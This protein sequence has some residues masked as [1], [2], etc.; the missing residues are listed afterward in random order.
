MYSMSICL[1]PMCLFIVML[2]VTLLSMEEI[3]NTYLLT[4][5]YF[6]VKALINR[7]TYPSA[8]FEFFFFFFFRSH[9]A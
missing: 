7:K 4:Y 1:L 8:S 5:L 3:K 9:G 6:S 2:Y